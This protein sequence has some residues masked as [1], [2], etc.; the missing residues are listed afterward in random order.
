M[1]SHEPAALPVVA[2]RGATMAKSGFTGVAS[3]FSR[4]TYG[5]A[6]PVIIVTW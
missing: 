2:G 4:P 5:T 1:I 3:A 6:S